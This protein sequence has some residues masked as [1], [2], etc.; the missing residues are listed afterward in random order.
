MEKTEIEESQDFLNE[1]AYITSEIEKDE[2]KKKKHR[3][4]HLYVGGCIPPMTIRSITSPFVQPLTSFDPLFPIC[5]ICKEQPY[6]YYLCKSC[7]SFYCFNCF[8]FNERLMKNNEK[9]NLCRHIIT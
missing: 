5:K 1:I 7:Q 6:V 4:E 8:S 2:I 9:H 3:Y